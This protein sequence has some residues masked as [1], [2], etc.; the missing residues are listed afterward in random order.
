ME[1]SAYNSLRRIM[2]ELQVLSTVTAML[3]CGVFSK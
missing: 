1:S 2:L 3:L